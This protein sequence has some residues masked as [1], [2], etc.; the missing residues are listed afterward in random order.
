[1]ACVQVSA[2]G[3]SVLLPPANCVPCTTPLTRLFRSSHATEVMPHNEDTQPNEVRHSRK[4]NPAVPTVRS[5]Q[6]FAQGAHGRGRGHARSHSSYRS[7]GGRNNLYMRPTSHGRDWNSKPSPTSEPAFGQAFHGL[8]R[9][10]ESW[11][12]KR[13][14]G[15]GLT[16]ER[17]SKRPRFEYDRRES[18]FHL[19][20]ASPI[21]GPST[22]AGTS[23]S[24]PAEKT[25][26]IRL[27]EVSKT[28]L[29]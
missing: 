17:Y 6:S 4:G 19:S 5:S 13:D 21:A 9:G 26:S 2:G 7:R 10:R 12:E 27:S 25:G 28:S 8:A 23:Q 15:K 1:M 11:W 29:T 14:R 20:Q 16:A 22:D 24:D 18:N 3:C